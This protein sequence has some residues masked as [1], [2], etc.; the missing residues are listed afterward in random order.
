VVGY[1]TDLIR[2]RIVLVS[3]TDLVVQFV[4]ELQI[5]VGKIDQVHQAD[6]Q[7]VQGVLIIVREFHLG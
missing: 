4:P 3:I 7:M 5:E 1:P 2:L 6:L